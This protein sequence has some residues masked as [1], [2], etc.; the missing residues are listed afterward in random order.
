MVAR[1]VILAETTGARFH[2][3]HISSR[4]SLEM[5][6][7]AKA[8]KLPVTCEVTPHHLALTD[9]EMLPYD[10]NYKMSRRCAAPRTPRR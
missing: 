4:R 10:S 9:A 2:V 3:A 7:R 1:D 5:V 8:R 6:M